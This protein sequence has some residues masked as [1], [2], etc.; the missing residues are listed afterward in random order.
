M[1][2]PSAQV[3]GVNVSAGSDTCFYCGQSNPASSHWRGVFDAL[4][5]DSAAPDTRASRLPRSMFAA[6]KGKRSG[7]RS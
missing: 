3:A 1:L 5:I 2:A 6:E 4:I 7:L